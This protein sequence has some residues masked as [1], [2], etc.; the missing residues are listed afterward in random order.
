MRFFAMMVFTYK[1]IC[2]LGSLIVM[3]VLLVS[4]GC[5]GLAIRD[6]VYM[7]D[8]GESAITITGK[9]AEFDLSLEPDTNKR[10]VAR[11]MIDRGCRACPDGISVSGKPIYFIVTSTQ[12]SKFEIWDLSWFYDGKNI[13]AVY[14]DKKVVTFALK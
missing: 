5:N 9:Y 3:S 2:K 4:S 10:Y 14:P 13:Y 6:G 1:R 12:F 11:G 7:A 8:V